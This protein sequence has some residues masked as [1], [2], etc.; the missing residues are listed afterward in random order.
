[1]GGW[2]SEKARLFERGVGRCVHTVAVRG[3]QGL[4]TRVGVDDGQA[5]VG[6]GVVA[7]HLGSGLKEG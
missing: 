7:V 5:L 2:V 4:G 1:M 3:D 6:N